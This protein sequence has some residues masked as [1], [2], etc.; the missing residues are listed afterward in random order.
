MERMGP[1]V[2]G[3]LRLGLIRS[4]NVYNKLDLETCNKYNIEK[5]SRQRDHG[6]GQRAPPT[7]RARKGKGARNRRVDTLQKQVRGQRVHGPGPHLALVPSVPF[8]MA[9]RNRHRAGPREQKVLERGLVLAPR[10]LSDAIVTNTGRS[11]NVRQM[12]V[13]NYWPLAQCT[14]NACKTFENARSAHPR[15]P[16]H[17]TPP[18]PT[19][20]HSVACL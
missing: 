5:D 3:R 7:T 8:G 15:T 16:P 4:K 20:P 1:D 2:K 12:H 19:H 6:Q 10:R 13:K 9:K 11:L 14:I 17:P 18:P